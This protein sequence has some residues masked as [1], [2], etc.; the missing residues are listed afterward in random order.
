MSS[1]PDSIQLELDL[2]EFGGKH[3][4]RS[5]G[6]LDMWLRKEQNAWQWVAT[7][8]QKES[9]LGNIYQLAVQH[10]QPT[11]QWSNNLR[12]KIGQQ[13]FQGHLQSFKTGFESFYRDKKAILS[14]S[15]KGIFL[16]KLKDTDP[17]SAGFALGYFLGKG[18]NIETSKAFLGFFEA[19]LF[20]K[21]ISPK[22]AEVENERLERA[23]QAWDTYASKATEDFDRGIEFARESNRQLA[24]YISLREQEHRD[25]LLKH[26]SALNQALNDSKGKLD[27]FEAAYDTK[28]A[29]RAPVTYWGTQEK[30]HSSRAKNYAFAVAGVVA[31]GISLLYILIGFLSEAALLKNAALGRTLAVTD[32]PVLG[33]SFLL[34]GII[35]FIWTLRVLVR[36]VLSHV[37]LATD[38]GERVVMA[39]TYIALLREGQGPKDG[40]KQLILQALFRPSATGIVADDAMPASWWEVLTRQSNKS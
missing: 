27:D 32:L 8:A 9:R 1:L 21:G 31:I 35:L 38:S 26:A 3:K 7:A 15:K 5:L 4:F 39:L 11:F 37:H 18:V 34:L 12:T 10:W 29:L 6:D 25:V 2:A 13:D 14:T 30:F 28:L 24:E 36:I 20:E 23:S 22:S 16:Q 33:I 17:V 40:D 19:T